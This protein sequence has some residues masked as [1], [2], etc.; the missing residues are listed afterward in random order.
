M[1]IKKA[2]SAEIFSKSI[3]DLH[4]KIVLE[5]SNSHRIDVIS[6]VTEQFNKTKHFSSGFTPTQASLKIDVGYV[7]QIL[8]DKNKQKLI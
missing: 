3:R 1:Y 8:K 7:Y 5:N 4:E 6:T 2:F